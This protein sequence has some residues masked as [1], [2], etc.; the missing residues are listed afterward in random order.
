MTT[1]ILNAEIILSKSLGDYW[2]SVTTGTGSSATNIQDTALKAKA[3]DWITDE[4]YIMITDEDAENDTDEEERK[5]TALDNS[6]GDLTVFD[7][8]GDPGDGITYRIHRLFTASEKRR[9]L[10]HAAKWC[11]PHIFKQVFDETK[12]LGDWLRNGSCEEWAET[13]YPDYWRASTVTAAKN[14]TAPYYKHGAASCELSTAAG[15]LYTTNTLV[16]DLERLAGKT[17]EFTAQVY[18]D[19]ADSVR[20]A[21]YDGTTTTYSSYHPGTSDWTEDDDPLEVQATIADTPTSIEFRVYYASG[22]AYVDDMRVT[23]PTRN[24]VYVGDLGLARNEPHRVSRLRTIYGQ[25]EHPYPIR[26]GTVDKDGWLHLPSDISNYTLRIEGIGYLDFY[27]S[28]GAVGTDWEDT[29]DIDSP[30][31]EIL[32]AGAAVYLC[33]QMIVPNFTSGTS[34][35]WKEA[36]KYW[37][38]EYRDRYAKFGMLPPN[39]MINWGV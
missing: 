13:S 2:S 38:G 27:D 37:Q 36:L 8:S 32:V 16:P 11:F 21:V 1:S 24:M 26:D 22:T 29:I 4:T 23:G 7:L 31:T 15:Y 28:D 17:V 34:E 6:S 25:A 19:T 30:Q 18:A 9:A 33:N 35:S 3:N 12:V 5:A 39:T 14:T 20:L 10:V